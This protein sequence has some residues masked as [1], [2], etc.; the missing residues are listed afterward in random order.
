MVSELKLNIPFR[1]EGGK[2]DTDNHCVQLAAACGIFNYNKTVS[3]KFHAISTLE[4][5]ENRNK[6]GVVPGRMR[7]IIKALRKML[8]ELSVKF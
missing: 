2:K 3:N 8:D 5:G 7:I 6:Q 4:T 1:Q